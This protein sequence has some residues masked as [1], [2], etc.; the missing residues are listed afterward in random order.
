MLPVMMT[1]IV[2][3]DDDTR[4]WR[5][6]DAVQRATLLR[7]AGT[8]SWMDNGWPDEAWAPDR[9]RTALR[10]GRARGDYARLF[11]RIRSANRLN[12]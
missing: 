10:P 5:V 3:S 12:R 1:N 11:A 4:N 2:L 8:Y 7:S 9:H 6:P